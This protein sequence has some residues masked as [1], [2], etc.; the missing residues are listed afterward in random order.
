MPMHLYAYVSIGQP[1]EMSALNTVHCNWKRLFC[2]NSYFGTEEKAPYAT[3]STSGCTHSQ[4][5][6]HGVMQIHVGAA[7]GVINGAE[8]IQHRS[9]RW[10]GGVL[11]E[12]GGVGGVRVIRWKRL[13]SVTF[14]RWATLQGTSAKTHTH[15]NTRIHKQLSTP[16]FW[17]ADRRT[18]GA[19]RWVGALGGS[20]I[21]TSH[22]D[23]SILFLSEESWAHKEPWKHLS[24]FESHKK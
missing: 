8:K 3:G 24:P 10:S 6:M 17:W 19:R 5:H 20:E 21:N 9:G 22:R 2:A 23:N 14:K 18:G 1:A 11:G 13:W 16:I 4:P 7:G 15:Q 12:R